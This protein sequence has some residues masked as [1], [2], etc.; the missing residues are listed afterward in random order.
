MR[1]ENQIILITGSAKRLGKVLALR[2]AHEGAHVIVHYNSSK[3]EAEETAEEISAFGVSPLVV[4][5]DLTDEA[6]VRKIIDSVKDRHGRLNSLV[7]SAAAFPEA[8]IEK[9]SRDDFL[10]VLESNLIGPFLLIREALPLLRQSKPGRVVN[11]TDASLNRPFKNRSHYMA[12]KGGLQ[13]MTES[14]ARE[15]APEILVNALAPGPVLE[16]PGVSEDHRKNVLKRLPVGNWDN[17]DAVAKA[18]VSILENDHLCG[19]TIRVD[20]GLSID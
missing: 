10:K 14:L 7:N 18:L 12:S 8:P 19:S 1:L 3:K 13:A 9:I 6:D 11:I 16:P 17:A 20:G 5:G 15:L 4:Q 2:C